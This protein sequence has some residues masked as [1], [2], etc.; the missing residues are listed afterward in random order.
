MHITEAVQVGVNDGG[1]IFDFSI[2]Y[3]TSNDGA[4]CHFAYAG[5]FLFSY[6]FLSDISI[7]LSVL[8]NK[9]SNSSCYNP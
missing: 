8:F 9:P 5:S 7:C 1:S 2:H 6:Q 4:V 3:S